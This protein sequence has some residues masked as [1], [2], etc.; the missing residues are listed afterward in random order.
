MKRLFC[1]LIFILINCKLVFAHE[2]S[3]IASKIQNFQ[4]EIKVI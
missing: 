4:S 1:T 2:L 3:E